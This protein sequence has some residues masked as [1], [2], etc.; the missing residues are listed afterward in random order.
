[1]A[2]AP[3]ATLNVPKSKR[4]P[5][6]LELDAPAGALN[7]VYLELYLRAGTV[8]EQP[9]LGEAPRDY[10]GAVTQKVTAADLQAALNVAVDAIVVVKQPVQL[11]AS[12][13]VTGRLRMGDQTA[14][15]STT[16]ALDQGASATLATLTWWVEP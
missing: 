10:V 4:G 13:T 14:E 15:A 8:S 5:A 16:V 1:M 2:S 11:E 9:F 12:L 6:T 3:V 7:G